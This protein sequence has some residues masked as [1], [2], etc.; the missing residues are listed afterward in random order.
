MPRRVVACLVTV[1]FLL[2]LV[3]TAVFAAKKKG[4]GI[5][6]WSTTVGAEIRI[7]GEKVAVVPFEEAIPVEPGK[8]TVEVVKRGFSRHTEEVTVKK[9]QTVELEVD[10]IASD[11]I[12]RILTTNAEG[13]S[14]QVDKVVL[15]T[16]PFD[17]LVPAGTRM[18]RVSKDGYKDTVRK[19]NVLAGESMDLVFELEAIEAGPAVVTTDPLRTDDDDPEFYET[20]WFWTITAGVVAAG[21]TTGIVLGLAEPERTQAPFDHTIRF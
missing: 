16:T 14:V 21:A 6:V 18:L 11:G 8:H 10:L 12:L 9:N 15:G 7:D 2:S 5:L 17:G 1:S 19:V 13:A 4:S 20:W 3:P